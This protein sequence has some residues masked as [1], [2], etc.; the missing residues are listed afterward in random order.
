[1]SWRV[2]ADL[3][4]CQAHQSCQDEAPEV[5]GFDRA[6]DRV[7]LLD[8]RPDGAL[9]QAVKRAVSYCPARALSLIEEEG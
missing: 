9:R 8:E 4:L 7:V 3:D 6:S 2:E 5:F 1:V